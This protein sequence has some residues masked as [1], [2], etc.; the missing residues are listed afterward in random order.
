MTSRVISMFFLLSV[1][2][3]IFYK[4]ILRKLLRR[5]T[6][7]QYIGARGLLLG[8]DV[9]VGLGF[10]VCNFFLNT[11]TIT[12][13]NNKK[14]KKH[15]EVQSPV[16]MVINFLLGG[17]AIRGRGNFAKQSAEFDIGN[18]FNQSLIKDTLPSSLQS[19]IFKTLNV[20]RFIF[21]QV[22]HLRLLIFTST[23]IS[24]GAGEC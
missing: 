23:S 24:N 19:L 3:K 9:L 10:R 12:T 5:T 13:T 21:A 16:L 20:I 15:C 22:L 8:C 18:H 7:I 6:L 11:T 17:G 2:H 14:Q 1:F 4:T